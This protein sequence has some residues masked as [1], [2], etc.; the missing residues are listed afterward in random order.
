MRALTISCWL[1]LGAVTVA[2]AQ[3]TPPSSPSSFAAASHAPA[4]AYRPVPR[5]E[6]FPIETLVP[7]DRAVAEEWLAGALDREALFTLAA[8]IKPISSGVRQFTF[9]TVNPDLI[10]L[11][12]ARRIAET[13]RCGEGLMAIV[14]IFGQESKGQRFAEVLFINRAAFD[15]TLA[16]HRPVF[17]SRGL[18]P[19]VDPRQAMTIVEFMPREDRFRAL[20][21]L[22]GFPEYAVD[23]FAKATTPDAAHV[24][25]GKDR[26]FYQVPAYKGAEGFFVWAVPLGHQERAEDRA[27]REQAAPVLENYRQRRAQFIG[28]GKSGVGELLRDWLCDPAGLCRAKL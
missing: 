3:A 5:S 26:D 8:G 4:P 24:G 25:R 22:F 27:I 9:S 19:G 18:S 13:F 15:A 28:P 17:A 2:F 21:H 11:E 12:Q 20:G 7:A 10:E 14:Q 1:M 6:C 16:R 23:F